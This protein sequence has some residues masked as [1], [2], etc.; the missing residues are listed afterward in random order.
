MSIETAA[1]CPLSVTDG[2]FNAQMAVIGYTPTVTI[3]GRFMM[4][5]VAVAEYVVNT[6]SS[7]DT[8]YAD[9]AIFARFSGTNPVY[10]GANLAYQ[11]SLDGVTINS[12]STDQQILNRVWT[13]WP[14]WSYKASTFAYAAGPF[15]P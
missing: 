5:I 11:I 12:T 1:T 9:R 4:A 14:A 8:N 3:L 7:G 13:L 10:W 6:E 15:G 2:T